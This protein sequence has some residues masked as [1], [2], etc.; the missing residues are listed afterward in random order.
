MANGLSVK[1]IPY[2][3]WASVSRNANHD[4]L[5]AWPAERPMETC[6]PMSRGAHKFKQGDVT[7]A[8]KG[9]VNAGFAVA[10]VEIDNKTGKIIVFTGGPND[11]G[12]ANE[13]DDVQ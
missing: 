8:I 7:K 3:H 9:A 11:K 4:A 2:F 12:Q 13:W 10:R 6:L 1:Q 5:V